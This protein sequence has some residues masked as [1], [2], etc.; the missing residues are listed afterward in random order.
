MPRSHHLLLLVAILLLL[1]PSGSASGTIDQVFYI[2]ETSETS[3]PPYIAAAIRQ[4]DDLG[5]DARAFDAD[6]DNASLQPAIGAARAAGL[7]QIVML[8]GYRVIRT[9]PPPGTVEAVLE[10]VK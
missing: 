6:R 9:M 1:M 2:Y 7:P 4:L 8:S 5:L 3:E 10:A